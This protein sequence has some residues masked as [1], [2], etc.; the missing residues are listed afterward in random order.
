MGSARPPTGLR[1]DLTLADLQDALRR[2]QRVD[3]AAA[4]LG[5]RAP[6]FH[7]QWRSR[8]ERAGKPHVTPHQWMRS[9]GIVA[10]PS[11]PNPVLGIRFELQAE[12]A[13]AAEEA[14]VT[15]AA[16]ARKIL[17]DWLVR[18]ARRTGRPP[19]PWS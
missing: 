8:L 2:H 7:Q 11:G 15:P 12:L 5:I 13:V 9:E 4:E 19:P 6:S 3:E 10:G 16:L 17:H 1:S 18:W 14:E